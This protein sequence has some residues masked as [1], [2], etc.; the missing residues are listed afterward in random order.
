MRQR[1]VSAYVVTL[2]HSNRWTRNTEFQGIVTAETGQPFTPIISFDNSNT[3]NTNQQ[4]GAD[5]P[6]RIG[7]PHL[8]H[9]NPSEWFN[10][11]AFAIPAANKFGNAGRNSLLGPGYS[12]FDVSVLRRFSLPER[13]TLTLEMQSFNLLNHPNFSLPGAFV[14]QPSFG[15]ISS[16]SDP[17]ELQ[18]AARLTF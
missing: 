7:N 4:S 16:A 2:P 10:T 6:N 15:I 5:R 1:F 13:G 14:D 9:P 17:R 3:G 11:A 12:S 18:I 8:A